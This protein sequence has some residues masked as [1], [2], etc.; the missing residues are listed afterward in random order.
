MTMTMKKLLDEQLEAFQSFSLQK[1]ALFLRVVTHSKPAN[2]PRYLLLQIAKTDA[3]KLTQFQEFLQTPEQAGSASPELLQILNPIAKQ[4][5]PAK[6]KVFIDETAKRR[7]KAEKNLQDRASVAAYTSEQLEGHFKNYLNKLYDRVKK[8]GALTQDG[9]ADYL[10]RFSKDAVQIAQ[11]AVISPEEKAVFEE[12]IDDTLLG[13]GGQLSEEEIQEYQEGVHEVLEGLEEDDVDERARKIEMVGDVISAASEMS[14][15]KEEAKDHEQIYQ[16]ALAL[17][18]KIDEEPKHV[19]TIEKLLAQPIPLEEKLKYLMTHIP[20]VLSIE[21]HT[22]IEEKQRVCA[23]DSSN[24]VL[25]YRGDTLLVKSLI[26]LLFPHN[27]FKELLQ[28]EIIPILPDKNAPKISVREFFTFPF[29]ERKGPSEDA[30]FEQHLFYL[31]M[32]QEKGELGEEELNSLVENVD[33][34]PTLEYKKYFSI[35]RKKKFED[36]T[37]MAVYFLWQNNGLDKMR[38]N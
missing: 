4:L 12:S 28:Q 19:V 16:N 18:L 37:F 21:T 15:R 35:V 1:M 9:I 25:I 22:I 3:K 32:A 6:P 38:T 31:Q 10:A 14:D 23:Q 11:K 24:P 13:L 17:E 27:I 30:W 20:Q 2:Y 5:A 36:T 33:N 7:M 34:F 29:A 26:R 8:K